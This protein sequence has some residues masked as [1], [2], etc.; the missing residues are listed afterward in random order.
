MGAIPSQDQVMA[1]LRIIIPALGT[2][3][4]AVG[5][6]GGDVSKWE[7]IAMISVGP[8]AYIIVGVWSLIA[9]SRESIMKAAAKPIDANTPPPQII[10]PPQE[11][12]LADKLPDNVTAADP[13]AVN[14]K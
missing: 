4:S 10:L 3:V 8:I 14:K 2:I 13:R 11:K 6:S 12:A 5:V 1:Q 7:N 9:N